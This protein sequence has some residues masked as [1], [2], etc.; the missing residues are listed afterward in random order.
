[1]GEFFKRCGIGFLVIISSPLWIA[2]FALYIVLGTLL[3]IVSPI[4]L[5]VGLITK[6]KVTIKSEYDKKAEAILNSAAQN[7][8]TNPD[9]TI[10]A[11]MFNNAP[12]TTFTSGQ[13][14]MAKQNYIPNNNPPVQP[15]YQNQ[16]SQTNPYPNYSQPYPTPVQNP[17][18]NNAYPN[19]N[20]PNYNNQPMY[21][22]PNYNQYP[23]QNNQPYPPQNN[24]QNNNPNNGNNGGYPPYSN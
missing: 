17:A 11:Y 15:T 20:Y 3:L 14:Q 2:F 13:V 18:Q 6:N 24:Q 21:N 12:T 4:K 8:A 10:P 19:N 23:N 1:M 16:P 5:L 22:Q 9:G 7:G